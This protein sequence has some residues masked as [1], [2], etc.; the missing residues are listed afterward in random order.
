MKPLLIRFDLGLLK[1]IELEVLATANERAAEASA[2]GRKAHEVART[3]VI[4]DL[5]IESLDSRCRRRDEGIPYFVPVSAAEMAEE[6]EAP[7]E[8]TRQS[9]SANPDYLEEQGIPVTPLDPRPAPVA[10]DP[11]P[12]RSLP[13]DQS[14]AR[15]SVGVA[16]VREEAP[17]DIECDAEPVSEKCEGTTVGEEAAGERVEGDAIE[18]RSGGNLSELAAAAE[19]LRVEV[20]EVGTAGGRGWLGGSV[21]VIGASAS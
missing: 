5:I 10:L 18:V 1:R 13:L 3:E 16:L 12:A 2:R 11:S 20:P 8:A 6:D 4:R 17:A 19:V 21:K 14:R 7:I 9:L 15:D